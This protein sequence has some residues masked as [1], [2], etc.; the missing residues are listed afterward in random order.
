MFSVDFAVL[1][2]CYKNMTSGTGDCLKKTD[3]FE[4]HFCLKI[5]VEKRAKF[6]IWTM[7]I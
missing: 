1:S 3:I 4:Y 6:F 7:T 5:F 2:G